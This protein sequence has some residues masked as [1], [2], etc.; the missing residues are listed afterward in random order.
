MLLLQSSVQERY[1]PG[2]E[3]PEESH[4]NS[5]RAGAALLWRQAETVGLLQPGQGSRETLLQ[6]FSS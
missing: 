1:G 6:P 2:G 4:I 5:Q 3:G